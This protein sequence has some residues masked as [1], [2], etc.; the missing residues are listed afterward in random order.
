LRD[1]LAEVIR[2]LDGGAAGAILRASL[3]E[4]LRRALPGLAVAIGSAPLRARSDMETVYFASPGPGQPGVINVETPEGTGMPDWQFRLLQAGSYLLE[5]LPAGDLSDDLSASP[6]VSLQ[7][8]EGAAEAP[9]LPQT[10]LTPG[11]QKI[12]VRYREGRL[13][14]GFTHDF[15]ASRTQFSLWPS[16]NA[17]PSERMYVPTSQLKAVFFVKDFAGN[18]DHHEQPTFET[19]VGGRRIEVTFADDEVLLGSTLGYRPDGVGFFV[20]P[21][22]TRGNNVLVFVVSGAIRHVRFL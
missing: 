21:A 17:A 6:S 5:L 4:R 8:E 19:Q 22:D 14:K 1:L 9:P 11:W 10:P 12:V 15:H 13:L 20:T 3:E 7:D 2:A 18:P 16:V